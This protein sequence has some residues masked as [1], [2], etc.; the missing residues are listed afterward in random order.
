MMLQ[1]AKRVF[2]EA[3]S[4]ILA[5][6]NAGEGQL[7]DMLS[8]IFDKWDWASLIF[9]PDEGLIHRISDY[10]EW[11]KNGSG[12]DPGQLMEELAYLAFR[13]L[14]GHNRIRSY[15]SF[16]SQ[17]DLVISGTDP[18]WALLMRKL[19][20][21]S[22]KGT[23][24]VE[25]KNLKAQVTDDQFSRL[26]ST[27]ENKFDGQCHLGV[28]FSRMGATGFP[29]RSSSTDA[30]SKRTRSLRDAHATQVIFHAKTGKYVVVLDDHD[31]QLLTQPGALSRIL[32]AKIGDVEE[33]CGLPLS[34]NDDWVETDLPPHLSK[35]E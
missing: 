6:P 13:R 12:E 34:F 22:D 14:Q 19:H 5:E 30:R 9:E 24:V 3:C 17:H 10:N 7:A 29:K 21:P 2:F 27:I 20:L 28:V 16:S 32:E 35:Y 11:R 1:E 31:I 8:Q 26:C 33:A 18:K 4:T 23:I 15:Q 25:A